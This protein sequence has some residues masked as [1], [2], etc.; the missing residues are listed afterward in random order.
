LLSQL[1]LSRLVAT[2]AAPATAVNATI[3]HARRNQ[4]ST[5]GGPVGSSEGSGVRSSRRT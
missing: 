5:F 3:A 1:G 2:T 4:N